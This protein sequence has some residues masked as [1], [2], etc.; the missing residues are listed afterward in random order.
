[1]ERRSFSTRL[2]PERLTDWRQFGKNDRW[3]L[4]RKVIAPIVMRSQECL[5]YPD[6]DGHD[7]DL[8]RSSSAVLIK[9]GKRF[10]IDLSLDC[11]SDVYRELWIDW[12]WDRGSIVCKLDIDEELLVSIFASCF[13]PIAIENP[14]AY[15]GNNV[16]AL[17]RRRASE[18][19]SA[20]VVLPSGVEQLFVF[21]GTDR[22]ER[23]YDL[24]LH[25]CSF[26]EAFQSCYGT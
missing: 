18:D 6:T 14:A 19:R 24:A 8:Y 7:Q 10:R 16:V 2:V 22:I 25:N 20:C 13:D 1:M 11:F 21:A 9:D 17:A 26:T 5:L 12:D 3:D 23:L 4:V 15:L